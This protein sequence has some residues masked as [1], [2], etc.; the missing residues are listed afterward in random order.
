MKING[1]FLPLIGVGTEL[2]GQRMKVR[3][4]AVASMTPWS[5]KTRARITLTTDRNRCVPAC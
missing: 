5:W 3:R 1:L 2:G 4:M